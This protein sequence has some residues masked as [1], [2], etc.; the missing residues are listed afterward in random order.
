MRLVSSD[1]RVGT[2]ALILKHRGAHSFCIKL[3]KPDSLASIMNWSKNLYVFML[4]ALIVF[5]GCIGTGTTDG[6][7]DADTA[8]TT[9]INNHYNNTTVINN[10]YNN[11][12]IA[13]GPVWFTQGGTNEWVA[14]DEQGNPSAWGSDVTNCTD[15]GGD[16]YAYGFAGGSVCKFIVS[17]IYTYAGEVLTVVESAPS[18]EIITTCQGSDNNTQSVSSAGKG[19]IGTFAIIGSAMDCTHNIRHSPTHNSVVIWSLAYTITPAMVV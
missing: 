2:Q 3:M 18:M 11:T 15:Q 7:G 19:T 16:G 9:A 14:L 10:H 1:E 13:D 12:T 8:G 17:T 6:E 4:G 5:S